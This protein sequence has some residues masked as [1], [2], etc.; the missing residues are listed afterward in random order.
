MLLIAL[1]GAFVLTLL[2]AGQPD[3]ATALQLATGATGLALVGAYIRPATLA[4]GARLRMLRTPAPAGR[5]PGPLTVVVATA[6]EMAIL[7]VATL[8]AKLDV[9]A[10]LQLAGAITALALKVLYGR[11]VL[12]AIGRRLFA[13]SPAGQ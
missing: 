9:A 7:L 5:A 1:E 6:L 4:I 10:S 8:A 2:L 12:V 11:T 13:D 3:P